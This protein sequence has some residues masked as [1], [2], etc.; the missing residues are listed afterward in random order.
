MNHATVQRES[1]LL[2]LSQIELDSDIQ[3]RQQLNQE[4]ITE[5]ADAMKQ[6]ATFP[7]VIVFYDNSKYWLADGFHRVNA[8]KSIG[9]HKIFAEIQYG[10]YRDAVLYAVGVNATY[11]LQRNNADK[12]KVIKKLLCDHQWCQWSNREIARRCK[13]SYEMVR[14]IR[15]ELS[16][17][18]CQIQN[19]TNISQREDRRLVRRNGKTY[20]MNISN[21]AS[22][23]EN[24]V[25]Q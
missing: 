7:P 4:V 16:N 11:G 25:Y 19:F 22:K 10:S 14:I 3:P 6:G 2:N 18:D 23:K 13:V 1:Q 24:T 21:M 9:E 8:K 12:R 20:A 17:S 5:Y 15:C